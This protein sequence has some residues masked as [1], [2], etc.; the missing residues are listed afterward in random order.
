LRLW[1]SDC[2]VHYVEVPENVVNEQVQATEKTFSSILGFGRSVAADKTDRI[3]V[4]S[5]LLMLLDIISWEFT[6][7]TK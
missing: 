4:A 6:D 3:H 2:S 7:F 1:P 5:E